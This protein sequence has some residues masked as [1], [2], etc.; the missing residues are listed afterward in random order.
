MFLSPPFSCSFFLYFCALF[1][2]LD[3]LSDEVLVELSAAYRRMVS[4]SSW[5]Q[6][7]GHTPT[8][9]TPAFTIV[10]W[11]LFLV[12]HYFSAMFKEWLFKCTDEHCSTTMCTGW[13][14]SSSSS[15][16]LKSH[17]KQYL[18]NKTCISIFFIDTS[19]AEE[20]HHSISCCPRPQYVW[21]W[22][23]WSSI[24][25]QARS[26]IG[27]VL[28]VREH[29]NIAQCWHFLDLQVNL[30]IRKNI[31]LFSFKL[32]QGDSVEEGEDEG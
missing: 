18:A 22:G 29:E 1:R 17:W 12:V 14:N 30:Q 2:A 8:S 10:C 11:R 28:Q 20:D 9:I 21:G 7:S 19:H 6:H 27:S 4:H 25:L 26:G 13:C 16:S 3:V 5:K 15:S 31:F 24:Q 32:V 23:I